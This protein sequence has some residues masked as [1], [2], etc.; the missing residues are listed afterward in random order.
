M[1][2]TPSVSISSELSRSLSDLDGAAGKR[3]WKSIS[4]FQIDPDHASLNLHP[5]KS[6]TSERLFTFRASDSLRVLVAKLDD[7]HW[8]IIEAGHHDDIYRRAS[9]GRFIAGVD[10]S[11]FNFVVP[12]PSLALARMDSNSGLRTEP[13]PVLSHWPDFE[14]EGLGFTKTEIQVIRECENEA[15]LI[16]LDDDIDY[17]RLMLAIDLL[18]VT[19]EEY[20]IRIKTGESPRMRSKD[21][22]RRAKDHGPEW[23]L[24]RFLSETELTE[25]LDAPIE[26][27]ML[28]LHP[29]QAALVDRS[30][31]GP[32]RL[33]GAAGTG[34]TVVALH[35]AATLAQRF[36]AEDPKARILFTT[37][38]SS[39]P[40]V[41]ERLYKRIPGS[42]EGAV[43]FTN[44]DRI[45]NEICKANGLPIA[46]K[47][48][49]CG[50][51]FDRAWSLIVK[52]GTPLASST[53]DSNY[54][55][56]EILV[57]LKGHGILTVDEYLDL[58]RVGR[59]RP[60]LPQMRRQIWD[61][62]CEYDRLLDQARIT[63][64]QG[65]L[66]SALEIAQGFESKYRGAIIDEAQDLSLTGLNLVRRLV[67]GKGDDRPDGLMLVGDGAQRLYASCFNLKQAGIE[68]RGR[69]T[70]L[71]HNYRNTREILEAAMAVAGDRDIEDLEEVRKRRTKSDSGLPSGEIPRLRV[72]GNVSESS[73]YIASR[74][75]EFSEQYEFD[76]SDIAVLTPTN[77]HNSG[78]IAALRK[79]GIAAHD[80]RDAALGG[81]TTVRVGTYWRAKGLEFKAV[82]L[83][84][85]ELMPRPRTVIE[86]PEQ[87]SE[88]MERELGALFV[89]MTR[90]RQVLDLVSIGE[91]S[92]EVASAKKYFSS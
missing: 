6:D 41:F 76:L 56:E 33:G 80:L 9:T 42:I 48:S 29:Q 67:N 86:D 1:V 91:P 12:D 54:V 69:S 2:A 28:F 13:G 87:Y 58:E 71:E 11:T 73:M 37:Y 65:Q 10:G 34:K 83:I 44:I 49:E 92:P 35:R 82:M 74:I 46:A 8:I 14:L 32:A 84:G 23:G 36:R 57:V 89:A 17:D 62:R 19:P 63:D 59:R 24:S 3:V 43:E 21:L 5:V 66:L 7:N 61:L 4:R 55:R 16:D 60:L 30:Y 39:L 75:R 64:Y 85:V 52:D 45:A 22:V 18:E 72:V 27:W 77:R 25:L 51:L 79:A 53:I 31:E 70:I 78:V 15:A 50:Q 81:S 38:I 40:P 68:I 90:A 26:D 47:E 20:Q 88:R